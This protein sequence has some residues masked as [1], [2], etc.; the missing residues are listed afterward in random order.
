MSYV[1]NTQVGIGAGDGRCVGAVDGDDWVRLGGGVAGRQS[2]P[3]TRHGL[4]GAAVEWVQ[5]VTG[6]RPGVQDGAYL[7]KEPIMMEGLKTT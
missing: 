4:D 5:K 2:V 7:H 1:T 3:H 6:Q